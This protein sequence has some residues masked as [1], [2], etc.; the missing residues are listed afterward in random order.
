MNVLKKVED[1]LEKKID[2]FF[3][4]QLRGNFKVEDIAAKLQKAVEE[5][6]AEEG[7]VVYAPNKFLVYIN[8]DDYLPLQADLADITSAL[9]EYLAQYC[10]ERAYVFAGELKIHFFCGETD[11]DE[12]LRVIAD[13]D[14]PQNYAVSDESFTTQTAVFDKVIEELDMFHKQSDL[15]ILVCLSG[16][17]SGKQLKIGAG[18]V[19]IGRWD[20]CDFRLN[21]TTVSRLHAYILFINGEHI[22][23][24]AESANGTYVNNKR[25]AFK[26]LYDGDDVKIGNSV[27]N[28]R[29]T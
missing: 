3:N 4:R 22:L 11:E 24:D 12:L 6:K 26:V 17:D 1:L 21:D 5:I 10:T 28:Y 29:R 16:N 25:V 27:L 8:E 18:R 2:G 20:N 9:S 23:H 14:R 19:N 15:A 13:F 7:G